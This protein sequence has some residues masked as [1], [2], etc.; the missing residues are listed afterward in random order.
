MPSSEV[1]SHRLP[2]AFKSPVFEILVGPSAVSFFA[3]ADVLSKSKVLEREVDGL[4]KEKAERRIYWQHW[5]VSAVEKF[6]EWLY[7]GD[8]PCPYPTEACKGSVGDDKTEHDTAKHCETLEPEIPDNDEP[9]VEVAVDPP[10]D[11]PPA[12]EPD[13]FDKYFT[14]Q[15]DND[16]EDPPLTPLIRLEALDWKGCRDLGKLSQAEEYDKW[17][18]HHLWDPKVLDYEATFLTH[19]E[20]YAMADHYMLDELKSMAWQRL[21]SVLVSIGKLVPWSPVVRNTVTLIRYV[22]EHTGS[23]D[24]GEEPLR[25]LVSSFVALYFTSF[26]GDDVEDLMLSKDE[27]AREFMVDLMDKVAQRMI[28]LEM[29]DNKSLDDDS[30]RIC[31]SCRKLRSGKKGVKKGVANWGGFSG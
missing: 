12:S 19:A 24:E 6:L 17:V 2:S 3:H 7:V 15:K 5:T 10:Y 31:S 20:L 14:T 23:H 8:Y 25:M 21:R 1:Y 28:Y 9:S 13:I 16:S 29:K 27:A 18:G 26:K 11:P 22:Y 4:W 30:A